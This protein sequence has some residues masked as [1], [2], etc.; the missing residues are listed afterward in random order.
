VNA[1]TP[2][3]PLILDGVDCEHCN[4][5]GCGWC[6]GGGRATIRGCPMEVL[7]TDDWNAWRMYR[8]Y[9][10]GFLPVAG[11]VEDQTRCALQ[12]FEVFRA[13]ENSV[14]V[15]LKLDPE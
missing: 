15:G 5:A 4:G 11:G 10:A 3:L 13:A 9:R 8:A 14:R 1:P 12:A 6:D 2:I 7:G